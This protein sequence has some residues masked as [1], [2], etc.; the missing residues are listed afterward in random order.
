M[1]IET[2]DRTSLVEQEK[3]IGRTKTNGAPPGVEGADDYWG[4]VLFG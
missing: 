3:I 1:T 4:R 2:W